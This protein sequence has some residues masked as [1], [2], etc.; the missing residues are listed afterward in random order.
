MVRDLSHLPILGVSLTIFNH[1]RVRLLLVLVLLLLPFLVW[2]LLVLVVLLVSF[3]KDCLNFQCS[4]YFWLLV[5]VAC[6]RW[7]P[8]RRRSRGCRLFAGGCF[9]AATAPAFAGFWTSLVFGFGC[10]FRLRCGH[11]LPD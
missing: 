4:D 5:G 8:W 11:K 6:G 10:R 1:L 9:A 7:R 2:L 3:P